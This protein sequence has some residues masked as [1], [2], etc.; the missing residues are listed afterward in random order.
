MELEISTQQERA[1]EGAQKADAPTRHAT[2]HLG[3][4]RSY[5]HM[6]LA[7]AECTSGCTCE[8]TYLDGLWAQRSSLTQ[9][10]SF[11]ASPAAVCA[12]SV[13][14]WLRLAGRSAS[15]GQVLC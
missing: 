4:L 5:V 12:G 3:Y 9:I 7:R 13:A 2:V 8:P 14:G 11:E 15:I 10:H 1:V 6:A